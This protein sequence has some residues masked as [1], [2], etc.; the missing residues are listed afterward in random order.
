M[1][2]EIAALAAALPERY[3]PVFG[4]GDDT[5][6]RRCDD[7]L[8]VIASIVDTLR[9]R[10][11]RPVRVLDLG[12]AQGY[13]ALSLAARGATVTGVDRGSA[14]VALCRALAERHPGLDAQFVEADIVDY[15]ATLA[16]GSVDVVLALS[17]VHH[18]AHE[19]SPDAAKQLV[20]GLAGRAELLL[21]ET[22]LRSE[23]VYWSDALP[24]DPRDF[25]AD[26]P[27][28]HAIARFPTHLS[29][30]QRPL[31]FASARWWKLGDS[32]ERFDRWSAASHEFAMDVHRGTRRYFFGSH[33]AKQYLLAGA[34]ADRNRDELF[35]EEAFLRNPPGGMPRLP[36]LVAS[37]V[38]LDQGFLV[39]EMVPGSRLT[40]I[41][42][43]GGTLDAT[44]AIG[45]VL[46]ELCALEAAGRYHGDVRPWNVIVGDDGQATLI[47]YGDV[48]PEPV[49]C[50]W[51]GDPYLAFL[52]FA[53]EVQSGRIHAPSDAR[54]VRFAPHEFD[55]VLRTWSARLW[56]AKARWTFAWMRDELRA[57][58][59][60]SGA[61]SLEDIVHAERAAGER[62]Q[63]L[64]AQ[65]DAER[66]SLEDDVAALHR[67]KVAIQAELER[68]DAGHRAARERLEAAS[69]DAEAAGRHIASL[70]Q[71]L[72]E[73]GRAIEE[74]RAHAARQAA[75]IEVLQ[76]RITALEGVQARLEAANA[77]L[78]A[79]N[80]RLASS[81]Q[82]LQ[83]S[84]GELGDAHAALTA[85][86][87]ALDRERVA[88]HTE[89]HRW[90]Q[91][92]MEWHR[93]WQAIQGTLSWR[94]T[95]PLRWAKRSFVGSMR[96]VKQGPAAI[97]QPA[98]AAL[99][100]PFVER[101]VLRYRVAT[102]TRRFPALHARLRDVV[103]PE[104]RTAAT[105]PG[106]EPEDDAPAYLTPRARRALADIRRGGGA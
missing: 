43:A 100:R 1:T 51:P 21:V 69:R 10:L 73:A 104:G 58:L 87:E 37:G 83:A 5:A 34:A 8:A 33:L 77:D 68:E 2:P 42:L 105:E 59:R 7:R 19:R 20:A 96:T 23:P 6:A 45:D 102:L 79:T 60:G 84:L 90:W 81:A 13:F 44:R 25:F 32:F 24:D 53:Q 62:V 67:E 9:D 92:S 57:V 101:P 40:G 91:Q 49:D 103:K 89:A 75:A 15:A 3:Q 74:A 31:V 56:N 65:R 48:T 11:G 14:N 64:L 26:V 106:I 41:V 82:A 17:V 61:L 78:S 85:Q 99:A 98:L 16:P 4:E 35:R 29:D 36:R 12:C 52:V 71:Q 95:A 63:L 72:A 38:E 47:D 39:R 80:A 97:A 46:D 22:A 70:T 55:G 30:V 93:E 94:V 18:V 54:A 86:C 28:V 27:F 76:S 50:A 88:A 66:V